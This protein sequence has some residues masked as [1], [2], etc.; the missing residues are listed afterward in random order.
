M[1]YKTILVHCNDKRRVAR[2]AAVAVDL[3]D[4]F[5]AH[6]IGL[7]VSPPVHL[8]PAG[9]PGTPD[10]I[11]DDARC[12]AYRRDNPELRQAFHE[13]AGRAE[14][15]VAEWHERDSDSASVR[16][17]ALAAARTTDLVVVAQKDP[18]WS[19]TSH[20]DID[21]ALILGSGRPVFLVPNDGLA[22]AAARRV[23]VAWSGT[24]EAARAVFDALPILQQAEEV[25]VIA[26]TGSDADPVTQ[27][28][29]GDICTALTRHKVKCGAIEHLATHADVGRCLTQQ[30]IAHKAD[31]LVMGCYGHS[32]L[33]EFVLGGATRHQLRHMMIPVLMSH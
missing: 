30:A 21:D 19:H 23:L 9:M 3:A 16:A 20:L 2:I 7:S 8:I 1:S 26:I 29:D 22:S 33:R 10:V 27:E 12:Q 15:V 28:A 18:T 24:R 32:R 14:K 31:L 11:V 25:R 6:L 13:A 4:R 5:D 17:V